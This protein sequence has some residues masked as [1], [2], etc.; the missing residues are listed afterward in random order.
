MRYAIVDEY[1][2]SSKLIEEKLVYKREI[3]LESLYKTEKR[4]LKKRQTVLNY[5]DTQ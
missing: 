4:H 5:S 1:I 3:H 2:G